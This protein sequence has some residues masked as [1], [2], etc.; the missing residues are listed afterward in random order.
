MIDLFKTS[1]LTS[2]SPA[3]ANASSSVRR[4][5]P[6]PRFD[7]LLK[8]IMDYGFT[9]IGLLILSPVLFILALIIKLDS[10]GPVL[11]RRRV[12]G[13]RGIQFDAFKFRTMYVNGEDILA[14]QPELKA[15]L[16]HDHKLAYDPR[17]TRSGR[18]LRK[19][20]L[21]EL[22]Q[23]FNVMLGQ[24][25]LIGPR[26]ISPPEVARYG[27]YAN[28]LFTVKPGISGLWQVSGRS[29]LAPA[30][31]VR[32]DIQYIRTRSAWTD[33][34]LLLLTIPAVLK[35]SGAY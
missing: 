3:T 6:H 29:N 4:I 16:E 20:S 34:K 14:A 25:S 13:R 5:P 30:D 1:D 19:F 18:W 33:L 26:M 11:F 23:L 32:L 24:M 17:I 10:P 15:Q 27:E 35:G 28:E 9:S 2:L 7:D 12:M 8:A 22:P 31:R 21:D